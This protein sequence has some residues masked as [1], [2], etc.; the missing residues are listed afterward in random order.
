VS[1]KARFDAQQTFALHAFENRIRDLIT[2]ESDPVSFETTFVNLDRATVRGVEV[3]YQLAVAGWRLAVTG[4]AQRAV[5]DATG[6]RLL[7]RASRSATAQLAHRWGANSLG[8]QL[9]GVASRPDL[10]FGSFPS[11]RVKNGGYT[12]VHLTG[13][14]RLTPALTLSARVENAL[15]RRY[16]TVFGYRQAGAA[17]TGT[18]RYLF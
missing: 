7:R 12:L 8:V 4:N 15:D 10:D 2:T 1:F 3:D 13:E 14:A 6:E 9:Q 5:D 18:L 11:Q 16:T 17:A